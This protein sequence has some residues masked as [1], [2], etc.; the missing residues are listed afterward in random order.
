MAQSGGEDYWMDLRVLDYK[1]NGTLNGAPPNAVEHC[2][3]VLTQVF[4]FHF[5]E[6]C[7]LVAPWSGDR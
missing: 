6:L 4:I 2:K 7:F 1:A 3:L 5:I